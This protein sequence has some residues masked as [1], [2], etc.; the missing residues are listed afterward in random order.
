MIGIYKITNKI[1]NKS[2]I[3]QSTCIER[4]FA[5][6]K[7][8]YEQQRFSE[9]PLYKAIHKYGINNFTFEVL[10]ECSVEE[11]DI[12]EK[13]YIKYYKTLCHEHGYN[14]CSGG[15]NNEGEN[16]PR[17]KLT[18]QDIIDIRTRYANKERCKEVE[19]LYS[20]RIGHS[21]FSKIWKGETWTYIMP[22]IYTEE[23][24][25]YHLHDTGQKG[26][27]NGRAKL[28][29]NDVIAIRMRK[30]NGESFDSVYQDYIFT[31]MT[32]RSFYNVWN[33]YN[34]KHITI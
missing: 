28:E 24:K 15:E 4:R 2:Y 29:E 6:H 13:F 16:H 27:E 31:G 7:S 33:G 25:Q 26:S 30:N 3:G 32:K 14:V 1:N 23:N 12:R 19:K 11:L 18:E 22:D 9:K 20:D 8:P 5:Q 34:W 21:G 10:E 17:H